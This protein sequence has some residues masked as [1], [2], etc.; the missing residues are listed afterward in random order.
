MN[1]M[2]QMERMRISYYERM[3]SVDI[4]ETNENSRF[5]A[6]DTIYS[7][8]SIIEEDEGTSD[9]FNIKVDSKVKDT[10]SKN[11]SRSTSRRQVPSVEM[12]NE[13]EDTNEP[14]HYR[15]SDPLLGNDRKKEPTDKLSAS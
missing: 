9:T 12:F 14:W 1:T 7:I 2:N 10:D 6:H 8:N 3:D 5:K 11:F 13:Y 15:L 4:T